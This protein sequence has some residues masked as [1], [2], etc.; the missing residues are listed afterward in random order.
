MHRGIKLVHL[1]C[2]SIIIIYL[3]YHIFLR[4][5]V[6]L[7][8][9][10]PMMT[11]DFMKKI[12]AL[13]LNYHHKKI[14][15][16]VYPNVFLTFFGFFRFPGSL[17]Q[18]PETIDRLLCAIFGAYILGIISYFCHLFSTKFH[19]IPPK[20]MAYPIYLYWKLFLL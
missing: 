17:M 10:F 13:D 20:S 5:Q 7:F 14:G 6:H 4:T 2:H 15:L 16:T 1:H 3:F 19:K 9:L 8:V 18:L 11:G 12:R